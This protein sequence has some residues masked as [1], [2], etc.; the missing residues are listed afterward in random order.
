M[1]SRRFLYPDIYI[2]PY[3]SNNTIIIKRKDFLHLMQA[4]E[5]C[6]QDTCFSK[7]AVFKLMAKC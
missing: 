7:L 5:K 3:M 1:H 2:Q 6:K 4:A